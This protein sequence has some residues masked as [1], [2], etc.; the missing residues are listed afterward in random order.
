MQETEKVLNILSVEWSRFFVIRSDYPQ[1]VKYQEL[2]FRLRNVPLTRF[3][4]E[5]L[6]NR[7]VV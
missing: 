2:S 1:Q 5:I 3:D 6:W 4:V 7:D